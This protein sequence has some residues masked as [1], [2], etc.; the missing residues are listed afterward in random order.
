MEIL[1][2][3]AVKMKPFY[4]GFGY[5]FQSFCFCAVAKKYLQTAENLKVKLETGESFQSAPLSA[6]VKRQK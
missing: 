6:K 2:G 3:I 5:F 1:N 4:F